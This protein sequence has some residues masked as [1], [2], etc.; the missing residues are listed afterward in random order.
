M[1]PTTTGGSFL[2]AHWR[3]QCPSTSISPPRPT[4]PFFV[5]YPPVSL[6]ALPPHS[7]LDLG[8]SR[9]FPQFS[10]TSLT[11][12]SASL[13]PLLRVS[14]T[15]SISFSTSPLSSS[16]HSPSVSLPKQKQN[17]QNFRICQIFPDFS[18]RISCQSFETAKPVGENLKKY[19]WTKKEE[20]PMWPKALAEPAE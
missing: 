9:T 13:H 1:P 3:I 12:F 18:R 4:S 10:Y 15:R 6:H 7:P 19:Q 2:L 16:T 17:Q 5:P 11:P 8:S 20:L 14:N